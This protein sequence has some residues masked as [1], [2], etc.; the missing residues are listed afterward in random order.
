MGE[1]AELGERAGQHVY[2]EHLLVQHI[3]HSPCDGVQATAV[4]DLEREGFR[5]RDPCDAGHQ[6][7]ESCQEPEDH[8]PGRVR[9]GDL[10]EDRRDHRG[11]RAN[12]PT[13][14]HDQASDEDGQ[15]AS[16]LVG[17]RATDDLSR[18]HSDEEGRQCQ[19]HQ[20][21]GR[22]EVGNEMES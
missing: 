10:S 18:A 3:G 4:A 9:D 13:E 2:V 6:H 15:A 20:V 14:R 12:D 19:A 11:E 16:L 22:R 17:D 8:S 5:D 7:D 21:Q 1:H